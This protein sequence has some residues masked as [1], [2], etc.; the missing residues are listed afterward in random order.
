MHVSATISSVL[1]EAPVRTD[2]L[3][4]ATPA[5]AKRGQTYLLL[6]GNNVTAARF[7]E[8]GSLSATQFTLSAQPTVS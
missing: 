7:K 3:V 5:S 6:F 2:L 4:P 1:A 8:I